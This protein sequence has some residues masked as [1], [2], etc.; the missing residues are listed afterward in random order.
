M[1]ANDTPV[2]KTM[3]QAD[4]R[5][6]RNPTL[7]IRPSLYSFQQDIFQRY[8]FLQRLVHEAIVSSATLRLSVLDVG[9][10]ASKL[11]DEF[12]G[13]NVDVT[14]AD[15]SNFGQDDIVVIAPDAPLPFA[16]RSFDLVVAL[17]VLE[18]VPGDRRGPL[19]SEL[20]R[21]A[22]KQ[23]S[24]V[25]QWPMTVRRRPKRFSMMRY[26][27]WLARINRSLSSM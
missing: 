24:S 11:T 13:A 21:V 4:K 10:G 6:S 5:C 20:Q 14:R 26:A 9:S 12:L 1:Q 25:V 7:A 18:H 3:G 15:L 22:G 27:T 19:I 8:S 16:D 23:W 17:D 2:R